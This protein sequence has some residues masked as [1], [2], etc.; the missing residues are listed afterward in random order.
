[1][2]QPLTLPSA[3]ITSRAML[4]KLSIKTWGGSKEDRSISEEV[5]RTH[6]ASSAEVGRYIKRLIDGKKCPEYA[7]INQLASSI[8]A[9]HY[10]YTL[11]WCDK[12][13]RIMPSA[14]YEEY[15]IKNAEL[16]CKFEEAVPDFIAIYP[17]IKYRA[18]VDMGGIYN[19]TDWPTE[20]ALLK[21][22]GVRT[23]ILPM[24]QESDFRVSLGAAE[25]ALIRKQITASVNRQLAIA[26]ID[27]FKNLR[28]CVTDMTNRVGAYETDGSGKVI[29]RFED[30]A[31]TNLKRLVAIAPKLNVMQDPLL[32][33]IITSIK[34]MLLAHEPQVLRDDF[35]IRQRVVKA[36][37]IV[38][39]TIE[40][41]ED[42]ALANIEEM[43]G[44]LD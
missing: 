34:G 26:M 22:F 35:V 11:P 37:E 10:Q 17:G 20:D 1:M 40:K 15:K 14:A 38:A 5:A 13:T 23:Q 28:E 19:E 2:E 24:P 41:V 33:E 4:C 12:G 39:K 31:V 21:K 29:K 25:E 9:L 3:D 6:G 32:D 30:T 18:Q 27:V 42:M 7:K 36:G 8:R 16:K 44:G 43:F